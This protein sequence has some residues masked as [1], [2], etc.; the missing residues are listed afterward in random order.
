MNYSTFH[1]IKRLKNLQT[2]NILPNIYLNVSKVGKELISNLQDLR[3]IKLKGNGM[4]NFIKIANEIKLKRGDKHK[5]KIIT[6]LDDT[7][8]NLSNLQLISLYQQKFA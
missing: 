4:L 2:L 5:L 3:E 6:D 7:E 8:E 1:C